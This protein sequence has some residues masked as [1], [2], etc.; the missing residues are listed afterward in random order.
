[1][2]EQIPWRV[3]LSNY[4]KKRT[5]MDA[6]MTH[7]ISIIC[8]TNKAVEVIRVRVTS[9]LRAG[10]RCVCRKTVAESRILNEPIWIHCMVLTMA[11]VRYVCLSNGFVCVCCH[12][13]VAH[14]EV[15]FAR[16]H[17]RFRNAAVYAVAVQRH[18]YR[19]RTFV[20]VLRCFRWIRIERASQ[21]DGIKHDLSLDWHWL[22]HVLEGWC[23]AISLCFEGWCVVIRQ[24]ECKSR[25]KR[26]FFWFASWHRLWN[27]N[28]CICICVHICIYVCYIL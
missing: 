5:T 7:S 15:S 3:Q 25:C 4:L 8:S 9:L 24:C 26:H 10:I 2:S 16:C 20:K 28:R 27:R 6:S 14:S 18:Q 23:V 22:L 12:V 19:G 13:I 21:W 1:M 11:K 17:D